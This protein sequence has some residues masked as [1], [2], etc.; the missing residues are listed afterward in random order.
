MRKKLRFAALGAAHLFGLSGCPMTDDY[1]VASG[2]AA[3]GSGSSAAPATA[4]SLAASGSGGAAGHPGAG[5][6]TT[7][8]AG[9][10]GTSLEPCVPKTERCNGYDDDCDGVADELACG[11][12]GTLG[13][14][15]FV[16]ADRGDHG[17]MLCSGNNKRDFEDAGR[18]C[19]AQDMRLAWI[20]SAAENSGISEKI[21]ALGGVTEVLFGATDEAREGDWYWDGGNMFWQGNADGDSVGGAFEAWADDTPNNTNNEDCVVLYPDSATWGDRNCD[22]NYAY[23]CE[24]REPLE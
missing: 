18:A 7:S 19:E 14:F 3:A 10:G 21:K 17:Y 9:A 16:L 1:Y 6:H 8:D 23:L 12:Q 4:G 13:C 2:E 20:E 22:A 5:A 11:V 15:G 24:E